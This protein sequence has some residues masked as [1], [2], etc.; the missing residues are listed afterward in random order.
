MPV[1]FGTPSLVLSGGALLA[2][3]VAVVLFSPW[4]APAEPGHQFD[5]G[6]GRYLAPGSRRFEVHLN[7]GSSLLAGNVREEGETW[8]IYRMGRWEEVP[9]A[10]LSE[11]PRP[12]TFPLGTDHLGRDVLSRLLHGGRVSLKLGVLASIL[13]AA[14]GLVVGAVAGYAGGWTDTVL[15]RGADALL[16]FPRLFLILAVIAL[17]HAGPA[18]IVVILGGTGWMSVSRLVRGEVRKVRRADFVL[19]A[20]GSGQSTARILWRQIVPFTLTPL[21]ISTVL[22]VGDVILIESALSFLGMG[23]RPP[24]PSWGRMIADGAP[25]L[26]SA[27]WVSAFPGLLLVLTV[28]ALNLIADGLRDRLDP[29]TARSAG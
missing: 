1:K 15:M 27:W 13:A 23:I 26:A 21:L 7:D 4:L 18:A 17:M 11:E 22:N 25:E 2:A 12:R 20:V 19:A 16:A 8:Q 10:R 29:L 6:E 14:L 3:I 5:T 9:D 24:I 28:V